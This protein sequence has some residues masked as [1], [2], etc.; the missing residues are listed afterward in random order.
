MTLKL[1]F[2]HYS[3]HKNQVSWTIAG[4]QLLLLYNLT[5]I[6][7]SSPYFTDILITTCL[8][9]SR[10]RSLGKAR[11]QCAYRERT[12]QKLPL[13]EANKP[14]VFFDLEG[15]FK[16]PPIIHPESTTFS[17]PNI[18]SSKNMEM[19][20]AFPACHECPSYIMYC[21]LTVLCLL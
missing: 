12:L 15:K 10:E 21:C 3:L 4:P 2:Y 19:S 9:C 11:L 1:M 13:L 16:A 8:S 17:M 6:Y 7:F 18:V 5:N 14:R 20:H